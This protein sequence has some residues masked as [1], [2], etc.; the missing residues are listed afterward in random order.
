MNVRWM[1]GL[2]FIWIV[3]HGI[4]SGLIAGSYVGADETGIINQM[5]YYQI[6]DSGGIWAI[7]ALGVQFLKDLPNLI[8][9]NYPFLTGGYAI[10][11][12][13]MA[14]VGVGIVWG[15]IQTFGPALQGIA[16][17]LLRL[18]R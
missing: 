7:P 2:A 12:V 17:N 10:V 4:L 5:T 15:L 11:R 13:V 9:F 16:S 14:C 1:M 3:A 8:S 6:L 18:G